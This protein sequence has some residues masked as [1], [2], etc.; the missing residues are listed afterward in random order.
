VLVREQTVPVGLAD[1]FA[2]FADP[3]NLEAITPP[4]LRFRIV[5]A[6]PELRRGAVLRYRLRL[7]GIPISWRTVI[8]DWEPPRR[9]VDVQE[10]GPY[11]LWE[12]THELEPAGPGA[13]VIRDRVLYRVP[14]GA[15][16]RRPVR[17][18]L[19]AIFDFRARELERRLR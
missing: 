8:A 19:D 2:F 5:E 1:A 10:R 15:L 9:F 3:W 17:R 16:A 4:W 7:F 13:T 11:R 12:H 6:P 14:L 18:A